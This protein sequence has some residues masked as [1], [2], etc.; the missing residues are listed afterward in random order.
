M[1]N[2]VGI[3]VLYVI[4]I[5]LRS[6]FYFVVVKMIGGCNCC[7]KVFVFNYLRLCVCECLKFREVVYCL[8]EVRFSG[9]GRV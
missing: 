4:F 1:L 5:F 7:V 2:K 6:Y 9:M 8:W 3:V